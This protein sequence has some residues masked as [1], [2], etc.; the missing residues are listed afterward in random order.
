[1][2]NQYNEKKNNLLTQALNG[3]QARFD[4]D[5]LADICIASSPWG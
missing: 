1:M 5:W 4:D 3:L 2:D